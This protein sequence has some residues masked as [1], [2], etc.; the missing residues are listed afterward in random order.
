MLFE[1]I[2][3]GISGSTAE[4]VGS[5]IKTLASKHQI[6]CITHLS[7]IACMGDIHYSVRK[8]DINN[9]ISVDIKKMSELERVNEIAQLI[10][11]EN[12]SNASLEQAREILYS[13]G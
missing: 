8:V 6:L 4:K 2:D 11:G 7:Q 3:Y 10:S 12:V 9:R 5:I 1:E 13:Y